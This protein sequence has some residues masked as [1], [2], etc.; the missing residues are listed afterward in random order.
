MGAGIL[1]RQLLKPQPMLSFEERLERAFPGSEWVDSEAE[2]N[3]LPK[4]V[5]S[6]G[7]RLRDESSAI[8]VIGG[9]KFDEASL[10]NWLRSLPRDSI[11]VTT[12]PRF[13]QSGDPHRGDFGGKLLPHTTEIGLRVDFVARKE[14]QYGTYAD[15]VQ[16][17]EVIRVTSGDVF[18]VGAGGAQDQIKALA[19]GDWAMAKAILGDRELVEIA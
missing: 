14:H 3:P 12:Q 10:V 5:S 2:E 6:T 9:A 15:A 13:T 7:V 11:L 8:A 16:L 17:R 4:P 1:R 18:L 19:N